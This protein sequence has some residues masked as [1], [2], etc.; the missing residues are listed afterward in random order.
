[1]SGHGVSLQ[2]LLNKRGRG[3]ILGKQAEVHKFR[4]KSSLL[5][6]VLIKPNLQIDLI[7]L[8][9]AVTSRSYSSKAQ[10]GDNE[11]QKVMPE[12]QCAPALK[13]Q[14][15]RSVPWHSLLNSRYE[16]L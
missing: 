15:Y 1:M 14:P 12:D 13:W 16:K 9:F 6:G 7:H 11:G 3:H 2:G 10:D 4:T 5:G 8:F